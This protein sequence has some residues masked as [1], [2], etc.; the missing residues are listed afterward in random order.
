MQKIKALI[1]RV[2][3][4]LALRRGLPVNGLALTTIE[5][6]E[7]RSRLLLEAKEYWMDRALTAEKNIEPYAQ[8]KLAR[9]IEECAAESL[10]QPLF[11]QAEPDRAEYKWRWDWNGKAGREWDKVSLT[12]EHTGMLRVIAGPVMA[13][14]VFLAILAHKQTPLQVNVQSLLYADAGEP[15]SIW[16]FS[17]QPFHVK[18]VDF[19]LRLSPEVIRKFRERQLA[20]EGFVSSLPH[21]DSVAGKDFYSKHQ[22]LLP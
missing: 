3:L 22:D 18:H 21:P 1:E 4:W 5:G 17:Q 13:E 7:E 9:L 2:R 14:P 15:V 11:R 20:E 12:I 6:A 16:V 10:P 8:H 19:R